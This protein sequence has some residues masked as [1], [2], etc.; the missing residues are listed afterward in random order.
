MEERTKKKLA[1]YLSTYQPKKV[2]TQ[3]DA[4]RDEILNMNKTLE[5]NKNNNVTIEKN[6]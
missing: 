2:H 1:M 6:I 5:I 3:T 4:Q